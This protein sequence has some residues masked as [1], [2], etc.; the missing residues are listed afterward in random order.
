MA[1]N[2]QVTKNTIFHN[3]A[4]G[5]N[6]KSA[7]WDGNKKIGKKNRDK[8]CAKNGTL[9]NITPPPHTEHHSKNKNPLTSIVDTL[10]TSN[11]T[12]TLKQKSTILTCK[13][14]SSIIK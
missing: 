5:R 10:K 4:L 12:L 9:Q 6:F 13:T 8:Q 11:L 2:T 14:K 3:T 7:A 1:S